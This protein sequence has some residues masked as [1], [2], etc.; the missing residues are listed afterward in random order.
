MPDNE[1]SAKID[2]A[3]ITEAIRQ[4]IKDLDAEAAR[5]NTA[6]ESMPP[7][8]DR[9]ATAIRL[10]PHR[11]LERRSNRRQKPAASRG[12]PMA[13]ACETARSKANR[14]SSL[15]SVLGNP[16]HHHGS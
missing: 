16:A 9:E 10:K 12:R 5:I 6:R 11:R 1:S 8:I 3:A 13:P 4:Q 7:P 14:N 2:L 15:Q